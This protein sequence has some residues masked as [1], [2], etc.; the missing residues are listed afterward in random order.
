MPIPSEGRVLLLDK[1]VGPTSFDVVAAVRRG[2]KERRIGHTGTLDPLASGLLVICAGEA[3][4]L[5]PFVTDCDKTYEATIR[6]GRETRSGDLDGETVSEVDSARVDEVTT[7][8]LLDLL[9]QFTGEIE[10]RPPVFSA[11]KVDGRP[12]YAR[13]RAG[14]AVE[15]PLRRVRVDEFALLGRDG[16]DV[17][18]RIA[19]SKGT[20]VR[21]LGIDLG[22]ALGVGGHLSSLRRTRLGMFDVS[23]ATTLQGFDSEPEAALASALRPAAA[24]G[25]LPQQSVDADLIRLIRQGKSPTVPWTPGRHVVISPDATLVAIVMV[26]AAGVLRVERGFVEQPA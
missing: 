16:P 10:Q 19:C 7:Q 15:A 3:T 17:R 2:W 1:P 24:L 20:Y 12:L 6:L 5:V 13:A 25:W 26:D 4:K 11:I 21:S 18:V 22:R 23:E 9:P 14:E 8:Q